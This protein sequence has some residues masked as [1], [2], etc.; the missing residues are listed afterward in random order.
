[1]LIG[2]TVDDDDLLCVLLSGLSPSY[3]VVGTI[4][5]SDDNVTFGSAV[6][7]LHAHEGRS[8]MVSDVGTEVSA[9]AHAYVAREGKA[10]EDIQCYHCGKIGRTQRDC[11]KFLAEQADETCVHMAYC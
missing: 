6:P 10:R 8:G 5:D 2:K 1:V 7:K 11:R 9:S 4:I 3:A